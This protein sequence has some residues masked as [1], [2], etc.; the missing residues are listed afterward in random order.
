[1]P[2]SNKKCNY[3]VKVYIT[4]AGSFFILDEEDRMHVNFFY[5][6]PGV[7]SPSVL[8]KKALE[9]WKATTYLGE[10]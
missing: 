4:K 8:T 2:R 1:M 3:K 6:E 5:S 9:S 7:W 10:L